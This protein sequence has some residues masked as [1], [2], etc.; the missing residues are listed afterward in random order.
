MQAQLALKNMV[1]DHAQQALETVRA[2]MQSS[3]DEL[4]E[5]ISQQERQVR[6]RDLSIMSLEKH[7]REQTRQL[8]VCQRQ[9]DEVQQS[10]TDFEE[11][12]KAKRQCDQDLAMEI[13]RYKELEEQMA[14]SA[15]D[16]A[17]SAGLAAA[18]KARM[19]DMQRL[20]Q[21]RDTAMADLDAALKRADQAAS[22]REAAV[23]Q[24]KEA[25]RQRDEA[26]RSMEE[27][28]GQSAG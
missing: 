25:L 24:Y 23:L 27:L 19:A 12:E 28:K 7:Q 5:T 6:E 4:K 18:N 2:Q 13:R 8:S 17:Q 11:L 10:L 3:M 16:G 1:S 15:S 22:D 26:L 14:E 20:T 9:F 21:E